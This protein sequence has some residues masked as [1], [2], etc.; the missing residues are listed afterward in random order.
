MSAKPFMIVTK[1]EVKNLTDSLS[2]LQDK[3]TLVGIPADESQR[4]G[5][6]ITNAAILAINE[7]GS[8]ANNIPASRP[9]ATGIRN[10]QAAITEQFKKAA[11]SVLTKGQLALDQYFERAGIIASNSVKLAINTQDG[12]DPPAE[13]TIRA[14]ESR[15]F[16]GIKRLI[17]TGQLRNAITYVV[18][19]KK[20]L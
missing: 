8:P 7:F 18:R 3:Q 1:D 5:D 4:E 20:W 11:Q 16:K 2:F 13:S 17:V 9:L 12:M 19:D 6:N 15:G 14:R 10:A